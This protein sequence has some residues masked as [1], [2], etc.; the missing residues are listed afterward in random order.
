[1]KR[2]ACIIGLFALVFAMPASAAMVQS[3]EAYW[4]VEGQTAPENAYFAFGNIDIS[5]T[6]ERDLMAVGA[7]VLVTGDIGEDAMLAGGSVDIWGNVGGDLRV[8]GGKVTI[9]G[10]VGGD[11]LVFGGMVHIRP[12]VT[13]GGDV[14][15]CGGMTIISGDIKGNVR[16]NAGTAVINAANVGGDVTIK[17]DD[18]IQIG[19]ALNVAGTLNYSLHK[20]VDIPEGA[21]IGGGVNYTKTE[22]LEPGP[23]APEMERPTGAIIWGIVV[24][25]IVKLLILLA[26]AFVAVFGYPKKSKELVDYAVSRFGWEML[27]GFLVM[28]LAPVV[29][30]FLLIS[31]IG[32]LLGAFAAIV[33]GML[34]ILATVFGGIILGA[35]VFKLFKRSKSLEVN[36]KSALVGILLMQLIK[37]IPIFGWLFCAVFALVAFGSLASLMYK[38]FWLKRA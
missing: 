35:M 29:I 12:G 26:A 3:G 23:F 5:G 11:I 24:M 20:E 21:V 36:W 34:Y 2:L 10:N 16:A 6:M 19:E 22:K 32:A 33:Y 37:L 14:I 17:A 15:A 31:V 25:L 28:V 30:V 1:M 9:G 7:S 27:R 4:M 8:A 18:S 38:A 13:V